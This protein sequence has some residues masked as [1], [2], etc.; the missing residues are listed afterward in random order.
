MHRN[1]VEA[2]M[3]AVVLLVAGFFVVFV[4]ETAQ[5]KAI[6]GYQVTAI[7]YK[8]GGL[9]NGSDVRVNGIKVGTV[10]SE[11]LDPETYNAVVNMSIRSDV[12]LPVDTV[13]AIGSEGILGGKYIRIDPGTEKTFI[14]AG[15][16]V[17]KTDDYRSLEDQVGEIIFL[18]S[19][20]SDKSE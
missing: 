2:I 16:K 14:A 19:G 20:G 12:K 4:Y 15:G 6:E 18:A 17:E 1:L 8:V 7:F 5:V 11:E 10:I 13:A 9:Q 3:G